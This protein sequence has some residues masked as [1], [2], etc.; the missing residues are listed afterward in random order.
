MTLEEYLSSIDESDVN[1]TAAVHIAVLAKYA[2]GCRS[3]VELGTHQGI[4]TAALALAAPTAEITAVDWFGGEWVQRRE[5]F[6]SRAG[7]PTGLI[8]QIQA[9]VGLFVREAATAGRRSDMA[10]H[11]AT[12]GDAVIEEYMDCAKI[13]DIVAIHDFELLS[14]HNRARVESVLSASHESADSRGR[15]LFVGTSM[16]AAK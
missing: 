7:V 15:V 5:D 4:A 11:D 10:F 2:A 13:A 16:R 3:I 12:H 14:P 9:E 8:R 1:T 6:W